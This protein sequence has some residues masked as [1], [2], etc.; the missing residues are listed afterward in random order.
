[1]AASEF[2]KF[3]WKTPMLESPFNKAVVLRT[4]NFI[5]KILQHRCFPM[6]FAKILKKSILKNICER[7]LLNLFITCKCFWVLMLWRIRY[8][9]IIFSNCPCVLLDY[10]IYCEPPEAGGSDV[11]VKEMPSPF[12]CS[13]V[14]CEWLWE[15]TQIEKKNSAQLK[16]RELRMLVLFLLIIL[17]IHSLLMCCLCL[18]NHEICSLFWKKP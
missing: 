9:V 8:I 2:C 11:E 18:W 12:P 7:L 3:H 1:M 10:V 13:P 4:C 17:D 6:E 5:K 15:K 14:I 16:D